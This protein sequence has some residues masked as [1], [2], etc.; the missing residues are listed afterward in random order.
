NPE[1]PDRH[2]EGRPASVEAAEAALVRRPEPSGAPRKPQIGDSMPAPP[3]AAQAPDGAGTGQK[4]KRR[5]G[6]R[7][8]GQ[9]GNG[10]GAPREPRRSTPVEAVLPTAG[11]ELD[12]ELLEA[13]R[14][15][16]RKGRPV[17]RYLM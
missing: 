17:G 12:E 2:R 7:G 11:I 10:G 16:E 15:R 8:R 4:R 13:R 1:L 9:G 5:R 14:G 3:P 6:G